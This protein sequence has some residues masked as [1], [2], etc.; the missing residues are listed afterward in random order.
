MC[1]S[2]PRTVQPQKR[3]W[4]YGGLAHQP[5]VV[6]ARPKG[7]VRQRL[8]P[9]SSL[10]VAGDEHAWGLA[11]FLRQ[12]GTGGRVD[13]FMDIDK[14]GAT[15]ADWAKRPR[16][17]ALV[18]DKKPDIVL[19]SLPYPLK[20]AALEPNLRELREQVVKHGATL[21]WVRPPHRDDAT[22][23]LRLAL[24]RAKI[25]SFHS[26]SLVIHRG[27]DLKQPTARG[28]AGWAGALWRWIG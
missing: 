22:K 17:G 9:G 8:P 3:S 10:L 14:D 24:D 26:E 7:S 12:L 23:P 13:V 19:L 28:Y 4:I 27:P 21:V 15:V 1:G 25:P 18:V 2:L 11:P 6:L 20:G 16:L 5:N